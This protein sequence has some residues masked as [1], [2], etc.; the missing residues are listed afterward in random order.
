[1]NIAKAGFQRS[2]FASLLPATI[3]SGVGMF[4]F[5]PIFHY[6]STG[7][8]SNVITGNPTYH[9]LWTKF[10]SGAVPST[11]KSMH[12]KDYDFSQKS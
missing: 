3:D 1:M 4:G 5:N 11:F 10:A 6:R 12:D 8:D 9:M 2:A 7:L